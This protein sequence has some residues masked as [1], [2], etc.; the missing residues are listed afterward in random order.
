MSNLSPRQDDL[1]IKLQDFFKNDE[2]NY[3]WYGAI[4]EMIIF[5]TIIKNELKN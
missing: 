1:R 2:F 5:D 3:Q 4:V